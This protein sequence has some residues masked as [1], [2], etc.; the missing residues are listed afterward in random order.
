[1][2]KTETHILTE[3][4]AGNKLAFEQLFFQYQPQLVA[5]LTGLTHDPELSRDMAQE[6]F[7]SIWNE[8]KKLE[9]IKSISAYLY[10]MARYKVY[11]YFDHLSVTEQY[12]QEYLKN[13]SGAESMEEW[14]FTREL[15]ALI[16]ETVNRMSPQR[17]LVY[18]MSREKGL[19]NEEIALRL[20]ISKRTVENHLTAALVIYVRLSMYGYFSPYPDLSPHS[21]ILNILF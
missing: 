20:N 16:Q 10:Q 19:S 1:M 8:R 6:I 2:E 11:D 14:L 12:T 9:Q 15:Q 7:L 18:R 3:I 4:A 5:F 13:G 21:L 17:Q